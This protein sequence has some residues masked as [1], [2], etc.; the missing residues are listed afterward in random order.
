MR[1]RRE[2]PASFEFPPKRCGNHGVTRTA[3]HAPRV[4][5]LP[6]KPGK[7]GIRALSSPVQHE[8]RY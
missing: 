1:R 6:E 8:R 4:R 5:Q 7:A 2:A 3:P